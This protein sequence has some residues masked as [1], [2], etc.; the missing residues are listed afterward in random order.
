MTNF[1]EEMK[2]FTPILILILVVLSS[3]YDNHDSTQSTDIATRDNCDISQLQSRCQNGVYLVTTEL[4]CRCR[5]T[6][7]DQE[8]NFYRSIVVE[9]GSGAAEIKIGTHNNAAQ[10]PVG[11]EVALCLN[12]TALMFE[13]GVMQ[14]GLPPQSH[15]SSPREM[16]AQA[17]IDKHIIRTNS[18]EPIQPFLSDIASLDTSI[19]GRFVAVE[20][21]HYAPIEGEEKSSL[22]GYSRFVDEEGHSIFIYVSPYADFATSEVPTSNISIQG[23]LYHETVGLDIGRQ[24][25]IK[26]RFK[27]DISTSD[28]AF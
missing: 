26:P 3:C 18:I 14:V 27:D 24:L 8:G 20:N 4:F 13:N 25:V 11:L 12:G 19:C 10:Y 5:I 22:E 9:D 23:I 6:S 1:F 28:C 7:S 2:R 16:E 17:I 15:D 21:L